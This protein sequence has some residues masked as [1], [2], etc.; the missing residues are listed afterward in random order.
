M[1]T[2]GKAESLQRLSHDSSRYESVIPDYARQPDVYSRTWI[3]LEWVGTGKR[4][5]ELGCSTGFISKYLTQ[6]RG[7]SVVGIEVDKTAAAQASRF[8]Q[9]VLV[10][11]LNAS[12]W[13]NGLPKEAFDVV[14]MGDVLEHLADP[15]GLLIQIRPLLRANT[16]LVIS[17]PNIV[18]WITR[19]KIL[20]G[21]FDYELSG[22]LDHTHLRFYTPK[23]AREM[24][25][26]AG[27]RITR[28]HPAFGGRLSRYARPVWQQLANWFPGLFALQLLY[29][30]RLQ[31]ETGSSNRLSR[32]VQT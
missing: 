22:T 19:L 25:E 13:M 4:V 7:C 28:F 9:Q 10:R 11:D 30:A 3:L 29:E 32:E 31:D 16:T 27:Y 12:D 2:S 23:T 21:R 5:L 14:L 6:K 15:L 17:L 1:A 24:I 20:L 18:H 8:C 26:G